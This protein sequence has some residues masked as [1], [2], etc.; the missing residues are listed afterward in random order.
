[1]QFEAPGVIE[2]ENHFVT[3]ILLAM[4]KDAFFFLPIGQARNIYFTCLFGF[5]F[6]M[7]SDFTAKHCNNK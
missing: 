7:R 4:E 5:K 2:G 6:W 3:S 1:M